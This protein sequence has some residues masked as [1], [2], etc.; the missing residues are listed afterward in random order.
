[1]TAQPSDLAPAT[2][3]DVID[4][5]WPAAET[6]RLGPWQIRQGLGGGSRVSATSLVGTSFT[7]EDLDIAEARMQA[8]GQP[9]LFQIRSG[10]QALDD[11]LAARGYLVKDPVA[12]L[13]CPVAALTDQ[14][15]PRVRT[16]AL[17]EPLAIMRELWLT[18]GVGPARQAVM[19]RAVCPK[20]GLLGRQ[21]DQ[22]G[23]VAFAGLHAG[24]VMVHAV[25]VP[26]HQRRQGMAGWLMRA[27]AFWGQD[28]GAQTVAVLCTRA[29]AAA[30]ALYASLGF[31]PVEQYHYRIHPEDLSL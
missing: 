3:F 16:F 6:E 14:P 24:V 15:L 27:A 8:L 7:A 17:W 2:L 31:R 20:T 10:Q 22:P 21:N 5:T 23:G 29:N 11:A 1:M 30:G 18:G 25:E 4:A 9:R 12:V 19:A 13:A 26:A 28:Q